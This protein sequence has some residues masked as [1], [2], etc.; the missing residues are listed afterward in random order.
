MSISLTPIA[1]VTSPRA[2]HCDDYWRDVSAV[3]TL[4]A[5]FDAAA[6]AGLET[7][8]H[9]EVIFFMDRVPPQTVHRGARRPRNNPAWP[10]VG[11][12][13]QRARKRPNRLGLSR[14]RLIRVDGRQLHV[15]DLDAL[16][17]TQI[18]DIKPLMRE[19]MPSDPIRQPAWSHDLMANYY[20]STDDDP[21]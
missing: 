16:D 18:L 11:I 20:R 3:I 10:E 19:C 4:D 13:A 17:G 6:F 14:C 21:R 8:S 9:L 12:F 1:T 7:F 5:A 2:T 15:C